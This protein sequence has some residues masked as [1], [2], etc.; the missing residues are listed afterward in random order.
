MFGLLSGCSSLFYWPES[1]WVRTPEDVGL[2]FQ[3]L[4]FESTDGTPLSGWWLPAQSGEPALGVVL[5]LH[6]NAEN[7]ST[8][9]GNVY[10][11]AE[12]GWHVMEF[13][14]RGFGHS[15]GSP[16]IV[17]VHRDARAA[18]ALA[19]QRAE[20]LGLPL[21]VFGQSIGGA[22]AMTV[23]GR[24]PEAQYVRGVLIDSAFAS[25][26]DIAREKLGDIWLTWPFQYPLSWFFSDD[27][28]PIRYVDRISPTPL[29]LVASRD[30]T[31]VPAHHSERLFEKA[32]SPVALWLLD[33][34][35]H[36]VFPSTLV[37]RRKISALFQCW[38]ATPQP[39]GEC[40]Q[41]ADQIG[42]TKVLGSEVRSEGE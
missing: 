9:F 7:I 15:Q 2:T 3:T 12:Q 25:Y 27:L 22:T 32:H 11:L 29:V 8:H 30:D 14:Y 34:H 37:G 23:L 13:D 28:S 40:I 20:A 1:K 6:G 5:H 17:G 19:A 4:D 36:I 33:D 38:A 31:V 39:Q 10:W 42:G 16:E 24:A 21:I 18:L 26:R 35:R 41:Q